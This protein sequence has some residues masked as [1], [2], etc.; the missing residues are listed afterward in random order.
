MPNEDPNA[1]PR[2]CGAAFVSESVAMERAVRL[3]SRSLVS[4][5]PNPPVGCV[6]L[7]ES[8][9]SIGEGR[10]IQPGHPH[11]EAIAL[12][13]AGRRANNSTLVVTLEPCN[14]HGR[15]PPCTER[16]LKAGVRRVVYATKDS[17][18]VAEGGAIFLQKNGVDVMHMPHVGAD[19]LNA[20]HLTW[21][22]HSR[23]HVIA[24]WAQTA[25]GYMCPPTEQGRWITGI[26]S[27]TEV[28]RLRGR[29]D[30]V[31]TGVGTVKAD[32]C[33]LNPRLY[34]PR[35]IPMVAVA[36]RSGPIPQSASIQNNTNKIHLTGAT[37]A[38]QLATLAKMNIQV[39][40]LEAG[41]TL[42]HAYWQSGLIDE[43]WVFVG[44]VSMPNG[45]GKSPIPNPRETLSL[46]PQGATMSFGPDRLYRLPI[47]AK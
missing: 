13:Q 21:S 35:Q 1:A 5:R 6:V 8:G 28:H 12:D 44:P 42:L 47:A 43:A 34:R 2:S 36:S 16:I 25:E 37:S 11:A 31:L 26:A 15:T 18:P 45:S 39:V 33:R 3:G 29:V 20:P 22:N 23:P 27:R 9:E 40:L 38:E 17:N 7:S 19:R 4:A 32:D 46:H 30:A 10:H 41:P 24:K 14:H